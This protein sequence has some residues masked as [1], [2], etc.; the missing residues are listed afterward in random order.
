MQ[1]RRPTASWATF[2]KSIP[3][4]TAEVNHPCS[5]VK[6][7]IHSAMLS[8]GLP[9]PTDVDRLE[10]VLQKIM[11]I[12]GLE[13]KMYTEM[14]VEQSLISLGRKQP[15]PCLFTV[16]HYLMETKKNMEPGYSQSCPVTG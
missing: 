13:R 7:H 9:F 14:L 4:R 8:A 5:A 6:K 2:R 1:T 10:E 12:K 15:R 3:R 11:M 16:F